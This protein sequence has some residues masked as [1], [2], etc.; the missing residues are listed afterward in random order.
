[1]KPDLRD[2]L[3]TPR[4]EGWSIEPTN[5]GHLRLSHPVGGL[6]FAAA[7]PSCP[8]AVPNMRAQLRRAIRSKLGVLPCEQR[9]ARL[10]RKDHQHVR[11]RHCQRASAGLSWGIQ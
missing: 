9:T 6:V 3:R 1:M 11:A 8:R 4:A 7:T 10:V 2:A 5:G